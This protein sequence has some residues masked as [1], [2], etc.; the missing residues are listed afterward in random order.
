MQIYVDDTFYGC[1]GAARVG[2]C[3]TPKF[4]ELTFDKIFVYKS[5]LSDRKSLFGNSCFKIV[6][7]ENNTL[8]SGLHMRTR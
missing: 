2:D 3:N 6:S 8:P 4:I 5:Y 1:V 7:S